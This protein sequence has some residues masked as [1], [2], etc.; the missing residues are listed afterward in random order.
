M[1]QKRVFTLPLKLCSRPFSLELNSEIKQIQKTCR[2]FA[3]KE[4]RPIA[5]RSDEECKF[6]KKQIEMLG[7]LGMM[8][9]CV[10]S[11]YGGS[12]LSTL[13]LSVIVEEISRG[14]GSSGAIV[15]IHNCL[16]ANLLNRVGNIDQN[17]EH[18]QVDGKNI[19]AFALSESGNKKLVIYRPLF[20]LK[21]IKF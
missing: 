18:Q 8:G 10:D 1:L 11:K 3:E 17:F 2:N 20:L 6:P 5:G 15:S 12:E 9:I 16:Y 19:G 14:C 13:A 21:I 7:D 4:L